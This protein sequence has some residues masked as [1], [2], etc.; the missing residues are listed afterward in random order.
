M[1]GIRGAYFT[2]A[3]AMFMIPPTQGALFGFARK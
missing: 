1:N 3:Q 2:L